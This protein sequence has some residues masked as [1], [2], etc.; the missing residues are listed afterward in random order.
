MKG[1]VFVTGTD[2]GVGKTHVSCGLL[3]ALRYRG[4]SVAARKPS[5]SGCTEVDGELVPADAVALREAAG[6][7]EPLAMVCG[8]RLAEALAPGIA[9]ERV[10]ASL[11][12]EALVLEY[13]VRAAEV[14]V[15]LVEGAG[16]LL[17]PLAGAVDCAQLAARLDARLIVVVGVQLGA[18]NHALLT[19]QAARQRG[20]VIEGVVLNH[21]SPDTDL[22]KKTLRESLARLDP[23]PILAEIPFADDGVALLGR[24]LA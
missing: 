16:G 20:L 1:I 12:I 18:I 14:D 13:R 17:V 7:D 8:L 23:A 21:L 24:K 15:L 9:A 11:D 6:A 10:G 2:T 19:L 22:A 5:E 3:R 4:L